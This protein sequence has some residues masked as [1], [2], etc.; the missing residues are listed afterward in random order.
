MSTH[1]IQSRIPREDGVVVTF[2]CKDGSLR[3]YL[4]KGQDAV[5]VMMGSDP[6]D[7]SGERI[8]GGGISISDIAGIAGELS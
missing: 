1:N 7:L 8:Q 2:I 6:A 4:Y 3:R 5:A